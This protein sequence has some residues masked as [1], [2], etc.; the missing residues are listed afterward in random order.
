M[1]VMPVI[2]MIVVMLVCHPS[3]LHP[4]RRPSHFCVIARA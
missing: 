1:V 2:V 4:G 3:R